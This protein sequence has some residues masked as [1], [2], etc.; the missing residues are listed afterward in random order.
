MDTMRSDHAQQINVADRVTFADGS[1]IVAG[2]VATKGRTYAHIVTDDGTAFR[3]PYRM[4]SRVVGALRKHVQSRTDT[5]RAQFQAGDRVHFALGTAVLHGVLSRLNPRYAHVVCDDNREY[6]VPYAQLTKLE[7]PQDASASSS[8]RPEAALSAMAARARAWLATYHL[9]QWSFQFDHA[10]KRA[11]CCNYQTQVISLAY[12]YARSA[13]DEDIADTI[14][15][16]IA[17]ALVGKAHGH[18]QVWKAQALAIGCSG[19]RCHD[20]QFTPPRYI[21]TCAQGCWVTT[22][23]RRTRGAVCRTCHGQVRYTTY[24]E[25]RWQ[26]VTVG[27]PGMGN[28]D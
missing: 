16:E 4:L 24:T 23:E 6:R 13:T 8:V 5:V 25:E 7:R 3:V 9:E 21:V 2:H 11:G 1:R 10:T 26:Q 19:T 14:R 22:A 20:V 17:H 28:T 15:H 18:D 12:A 27:S